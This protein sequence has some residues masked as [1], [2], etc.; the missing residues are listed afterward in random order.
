MYGRARVWELLTIVVALR[1]RRLA[2]ALRTAPVAWSFAAAAA[3][4]AAAVAATSISRG[5]LGVN[6]VVE[7]I[8]AGLATS[9]AIAEGS[10]AARLQ[11]EGRRH[12]HR[13]G[14]QH[15]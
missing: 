4:I 12:I 11:R 3:A 1:L 13:R 6:S 5:H 14:L 2:G 15:R 9:I 10:P 8:V 7:L